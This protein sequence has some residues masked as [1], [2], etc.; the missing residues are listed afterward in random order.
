LKLRAL[1]CLLWLAP[2]WLDAGPVSAVPASK[3]ELLKV[4]IIEKVARFIDW[5]GMRPA[6]FV[7]CVAHDHPQLAILQSYYDSNPILD[8]PVQVRPLRR[9]DNLSQ[10]RAALLA[11]GEPSDSLRLQ[12]MSGR[13]HV[14]LLAEGAEMARAGVHIGFYFDM[15]KMRLEVNR[16]TLEASGL[17]ASYKLLEVAKVV[18]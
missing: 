9:G 8:M 4:V 7:L 14:L 12:S 2:A 18:E 15:N 10:C 17:K 3:A 13:E 1:A 6:Q 11:P 16:K 5:P